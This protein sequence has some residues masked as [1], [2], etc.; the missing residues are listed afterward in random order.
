LRY[1]NT[2][3][4]S[5]II[6]SYNTKDLTIQAIG[7]VIESIK[8][9]DLLRTKSEIIVIDNKSSDLSVATIKEVI[10]QSS[11]PIQ[12]I[13]NPTNTGFA[14]ANNLGIQKSTGKYMLL[15]NSDTVV[16][17]NALEK[18][19]SAMEAVPVNESTAHLSS[20]Q[21]RLDRL[22]V[23]SAHLLN[24]NGTSQPQGG[25]FPTL[26]S[27]SAHMF[28][29]DD[30]PLIGKFLPSTQHT[31]KNTRSFGSGK[32]DLHQ[33]DWVGGTAV[34]IR[35]TTLEEI[36]PLDQNI[37]MYGEDIELCMRAK[38]HHWDIA[39]DPEAKIVHFGSASSSSKNAILGE[40][41]GY[42]YI[43][44]KHKPI[45]QMPFLK[46]ILRIGCYLRILLFSLL[47]K[48]EKASIYMTAIKDVLR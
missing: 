14:Q 4:L 12:L 33:Q 17:D 28:F 13:E 7:S 45:W 27:L 3:L 44:A 38:A 48:K 19:V 29:L 30:L 39:I 11:I 34:L 15:L 16:Q 41:K 43:W 42:L 40:L 1:P 2:M 31:G 21:G 10:A 8:S 22:G 46:L 32:N 25:S 18:M 5:I 20:Y 36:G 35:R 9:S 24:P 26:L 37:F 47:K 23:L 6:I